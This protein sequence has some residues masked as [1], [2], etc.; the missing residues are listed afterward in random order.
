MPTRSAYFAAVR[1]ATT[2][3][4]PGSQSRTMGVRLIAWSTSDDACCQLVGVLEHPVDTLGDVGRIAGGLHPSGGTR[5]ATR[6]G[7][8]DDACLFPPREHRVVRQIGEVE[9]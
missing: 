9:A 5:E 4:R 7:A 3:S 8:L 2:S 6:V 1:M